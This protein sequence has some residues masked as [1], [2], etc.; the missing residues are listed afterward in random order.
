MAAQLA[1]LSGFPLSSY[2]LFAVIAAA[3]RYHRS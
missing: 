2:V 3:G 1:L